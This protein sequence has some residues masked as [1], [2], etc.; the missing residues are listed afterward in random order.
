MKEDKTT[1]KKNLNELEIS[2]LPYTEFKVMVIKVLTEQSENFNKD[3]EY[4][5]VLNRSHRT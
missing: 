3:I 4:K 5:K 1:G 2:N